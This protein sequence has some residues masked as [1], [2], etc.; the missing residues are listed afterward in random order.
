V[1]P[2]IKVRRQSGSYGMHAW[3]RT[4][5]PLE[6]IDIIPP[7]DPDTS[8]FAQFMDESTPH[9][10]AVS[11]RPPARHHKRSVVAVLR[12]LAT[13]SPCVA[14]AAALVFWR[15]LRSASRFLPRRFPVSPCAIRVMSRGLSVDPLRTQP[16]YTV[17][18]P[19][20]LSPMNIKSRAVTSGLSDFLHNARVSAGTGVR[21]RLIFDALSHSTLVV[22]YQPRQQDAIADRLF[23]DAHLSPDSATV[24]RSGASKFLVDQE[25][26]LT[27]KDDAV[28][29]VGDLLPAVGTDF[30][31]GD[32]PLPWVSGKEN[33]LADALSRMAIDPLVRPEEAGH[34]ML[35][36]TPQ[37]LDFD[38]FAVIVAAAARA[39]GGVTN[40]MLE[41]DSVRAAPHLDFAHAWL[42]APLFHPCLDRRTLCQCIVTLFTNQPQGVLMWGTHE[43]PQ[44][45]RFLQFVE[46]HRWEDD[47]SRAYRE[48]TLLPSGDM[49][50]R[51][52]A[53][54]DDGNTVA[55]ME[56]AHLH[57]LHIS[58]ER[59]FRDDGPGQ[60]ADSEELQLH[61]SC[62]SSETCVLIDCPH[63]EDAT[64]TRLVDFREGDSPRAG[65]VEA[66]PA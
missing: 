10:I 59:L 47:F 16:I 45:S 46:P 23:R 57:V 65:R 20:W 42:P 8:V 37:R 28:L 4:N 29:Q 43:S 17:N 52:R 33:A 51:A 62:A 58:S 6:T 1:P 50:P 63:R 49:I 61:E 54:S 30:W 5:T 64:V 18:R 3:L 13:R 53:S 2:Y 9:E 11:R 44:P 38:S 12:S 60:A 7:W 21:L 31:S 40:D 56:V 48:I 26:V 19:D 34:L 55:V 32:S 35:H 66:L 14:G 39:F 22:Q 15:L 27:E 36:A 41:F 24:D 25:L